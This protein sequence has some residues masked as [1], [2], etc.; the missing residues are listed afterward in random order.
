MPFCLFMGMALE[1]AGLSVST[2]LKKT[3]FVLHGIS[4]VNVLGNS[5][6]S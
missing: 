5:Y 4:I 2:T 6:I 3:K 1:V